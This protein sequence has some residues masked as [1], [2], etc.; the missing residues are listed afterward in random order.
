MS[1]MVGFDDDTLHWIS[2]AVRESVA[3]AM[4]HG[5]K[6]DESKRVDVEF[7]TSPADQPSELVI[8]VRDQGEGFDP[9]A[10]RRPAGAREPAEV[11]RPRHLPHPQLH[12]RRRACGVSPRAAWKSAWSSASRRPTARLVTPPDP[13]YLATAIEVVTRAGAIQRARF[14]SDVRGRQEGHHRSGDRGRRRGRARV[15]RADRCAFSRPRHP[16]RGDWAARRLPAPRTAGSST[17]STAP[18][19]S[20]T[21]CRSSARRWPSRSTARPWSARCSTRT[22]R[23][24]S[25][26]SA[27]SAPG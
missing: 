24:C 7:T 20:R 1:R 3:N 23:S 19:T 10:G 9:E 8:L 14:G 18:P 22:G 13:R 5:N 21:A 12:G 16:G 6:G 26:P 15:P 17:R 11:E 4:K 25:P 2:I 27:A